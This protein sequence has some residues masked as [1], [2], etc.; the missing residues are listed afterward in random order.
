M[1]KIA[2]ALGRMA[3]GVPKKFSKKELL[4]RKLLM[5]ELNRKRKEARNA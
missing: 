3:R 2:Q 1:N 5:V 4:R